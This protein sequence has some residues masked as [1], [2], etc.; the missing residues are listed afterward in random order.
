M[1]TSNYLGY[2]P[3]VFADYQAQ[4][5]RWCR[6]VVEPDTFTGERFNIGVGIIDNTGK[7]LVKVMSEK[8]RLECIFDQRDAESIL[9]MAAVAKKC[10]EEDRPPLFA[11]ISFGEL[12]PLFNQE[13]SIAINELFTDQV[14]FALPQRNEAARP[15]GWLTKKET[16]HEIFKLISER[17]PANQ[18]SV[19]MPRAPTIQVQTK[20]GLV[21]P[22][23]VPLQLAN[24]AGALESAC[25]SPAIVKSHLMDAMLD[26][27]THANAAGLTRAGMF[28]LRSSTGLS[29]KSLLTLDNTIDDVLWRVPKSWC[30]EIEDTTPKLTDKILAWAQI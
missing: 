26:I 15:K 20:A 27:Q 1:S 10:F 13:P 25:Y 7:R 12:L 24:G 19:L 6:I 5:G 17:L 14:T 2:E 28:I 30:I 29:R 21:K 18:A 4:T 22:V 11:N 16:R 8:G 3:P 23:N 9:M